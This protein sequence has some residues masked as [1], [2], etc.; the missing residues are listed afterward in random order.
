MLSIEMNAA[1]EVMNLINDIQN[2][3]LP[4]G[5]GDGGRDL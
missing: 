2:C 4:F 3:S 1:M 5:E